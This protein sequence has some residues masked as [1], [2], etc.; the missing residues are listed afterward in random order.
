MV[1]LKLRIFEW[2][3]LLCLKRGNFQ[4]RGRFYIKFKLFFSN[5]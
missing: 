5:A 2:I 4:P 1:I 3:N